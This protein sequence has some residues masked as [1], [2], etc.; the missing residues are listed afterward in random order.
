[1]KKLNFIEN[2]HLLLIPCGYKCGFRFLIARAA[3]QIA[4]FNI[5]SIVLSI[6]D[7]AMANDLEI[8]AENIFPIT[9]IYER[10]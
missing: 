7:D 4:K 6:A 2:F 3:H 9:R 1:M 10:Q 5:K 8:I